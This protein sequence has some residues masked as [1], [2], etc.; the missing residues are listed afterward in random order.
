MRSKGLPSHN[1]C[2]R[3]VIATPLYP[4]EI[5]GPATH[6][7]FLEHMLP[8]HDIEVETVPFAHVRH[9]PK[10]LRHIQ[11]AWRLWRAARRA[12]VLFAQDTV[13][14]G[15]PALLAA[16]LARVPLLVRVPGDHAW[17]QG[18]QRFGVTDSL[19]E[20]QKKRYGWRIEL[21]R[22]V[23]RAVVRHATLVTVPS[24]YFKRIVGE[25]VTR[26][27]IRVIYNGVDL[28]LKP[29]RPPRLPSRP[30]FVS[31]GR[32]VPW[33]GFGELIELVERMPGWTLV[34]VGDGPLRTELADQVRA[35][36]VEDR[37]IFT[38]SLPRAEVAGWLGVSDAFV[39]N[40]S[41]ESFSYQVV[42]AMGAGV[43]VIAPA[44]GSIPELIHDGVEGVLVTPGDLQSIEKALRSVHADSALW[45]G[46]TEAARHAA[47]RFSADATAQAF[48]QAV[49]DVAR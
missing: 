36:G 22:R 29:V 43:P 12:D 7:L 46:R 8:A 3:L 25:W 40:S 5:G 27:D 35:R 31:I 18:R 48:A 37:V 21:L 32:L 16:R 41:F 24:E 45:R 1:L 42:E 28:A 49:R 26:T 15:L 14:A 30:F 13:S 6:T 38:G 33:K 9:W 44:I 17:E 2:M 23:A 10:G 20:F 19:E 4:P 34:I 47:A 39:L 11:Y